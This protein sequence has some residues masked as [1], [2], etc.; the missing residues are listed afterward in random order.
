MSAMDDLFY[1]N[2]SRYAA[3]KDHKTR[4]SGGRSFYVTNVGKSND[5]DSWNVLL[6]KPGQESSG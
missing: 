5:V 3:V 1:Q 6:K 4:N 2:D